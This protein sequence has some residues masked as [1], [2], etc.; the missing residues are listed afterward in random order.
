MQKQPIRTRKEWTF[1]LILATLL[2]IAPPILEP[3]CESFRNRNVSILE[4]TP[5]FE[6]PS[7]DSQC[8]KIMEKTAK[9]RT[10]EW[11]RLPYLPKEFNE[12]RWFPAEYLLTFHK[13][14]M[15]DG[16][17]AWVSPDLIVIN[18]RTEVFTFSQQRHLPAVLTSLCGLGLVLLFGLP[19]IRDP[20]RHGGRGSAGSLVSILYLIAFLK[21]FLLSAWLY[22]GTGSQV[23]LTDEFCYFRIA[24][25]FFSGVTE[26]WN[27]TVGY[28]L[29]ISPLIAATGISGEGVQKA[30]ELIS[31]FNGY[32]ILP[33]CTVMLAVILHHFCGSLRR[34]FWLLCVFL[35]IPF[36]IHPYENFPNQHFSIWID[37]PVPLLSYQS[38][39]TQIWTGW[40]ALSDPASTFFVMLCV[41]LGIFR[42]NGIPRMILISGLFAFACLIRIN[43][44][45]FAPLLAFL[46]WENNRE[47][48][49]E[50]RIFLLRDLLLCLAAFLCVF[51]IQ[52]LINL[53]DFSSPFTWPYVLHDT[54][55][56][57]FRLQALR[58]GGMSYFICCNLL[59]F[60]FGTAALL[61]LKRKKLRIL[62]IF[63]I[64]PL[65]LFFSGYVCFSASP[66]RF[67]L[68][69]LFGLCAAIGCGEFWNI[70][71][72]RRT[73]TGLILLLLLMILAYNPYFQTRVAE[74]L[75]HALTF[76]AY[77]NACILI[78]TLFLLLCLGA[79][80]PFL[81][82]KLS[83]HLCCWITGIL[84]FFSG[85]GVLLWAVSLLLV[86]YGVCVF[87]KDA[88]TDLFFGNSRTS[89]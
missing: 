51:L 72:D 85:C 83:P 10:L 22:F 28:P 52:F 20:F 87:F 24:H 80:L 46:F 69:A 9:F 29:L 63:W 60:S 25:E 81:R 48:F 31:A 23:R 34:T 73:R 65:T 18:G 88:L 13:I 64:F 3:L 82:R 47:R 86:I 19:M 89:R 11:K 67:I 42:A 77:K 33:L 79:T 2:L 41:L 17:T 21:Q 32:L 14:Q 39:Y 78:R 12:G 8:L 58:N 6:A 43:N 38:Y 45:F 37:L 74:Q 36:V 56:Q 70:S 7:P 68:P 27:Y 26:P 61:F 15:E 54:A 59:L 84:L 55:S 50:K 75:F 5:C 40:N 57:G 1:F 44:I 71:P 53:R 30:S 76:S 4:S 35:A 49:L 16:R 66:V 62:F